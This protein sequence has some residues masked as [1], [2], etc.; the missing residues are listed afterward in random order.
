MTAQQRKDSRGKNSNYLRSEREGQKNAQ[1]GTWE[2]AGERSKRDFP[3]ALGTL[4][5]DN[6]IN[7]HPKKREL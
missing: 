2:K 5:E 7:W 6:L 3:I 1:D 4:Q